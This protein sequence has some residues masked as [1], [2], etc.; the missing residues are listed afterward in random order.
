MSPLL[1]DPRP[2]FVKLIELNKCRVLFEPPLIF[3]CGGPVDV[4]ATG[5]HS[6]RNMFM[7]ISGAMGADDNH[8]FILAENFKD[9][10][11]AYSN[12]SDFENDIAFISSLVVVFLESEGSLTEFGM[13]FANEILRK[14]MVAVVHEEHYE[15]ESFIKFG[16]L[17]PLQDL[18]EGLVRVYE[19]DHLNIDTVKKEEVEGIVQDIVDQSSQ[20]DKSA[21]FDKV[22]RGHFIFMVFQLA[23]LFIAVTLPELESF[24]VQLGI[25]RSRKEIKSAIYILQKFGLMGERRKS[26][27]VFYF[28]F[29]GQSRR[30]DFH[31]ADKK[32]RY[33]IPAVKIEILQYYQISSQSNRG[34]KNRL[35]VIGSIPDVVGD[36]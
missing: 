31:L 13:F 3:I 1:Q 9:W 5:N 8:D 4:K 10:Q 2:Y 7:N 16:L 26:A 27:Q 23:D 33:D 35:S 11:T 14:K 36:T 15:S 17:N 32:R 18:D 12:L 29:K 6:I 34:F 19:I 22:E 20:A 24:L 30:V 28:A 21:M 25:S